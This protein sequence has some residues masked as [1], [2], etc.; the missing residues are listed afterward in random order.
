[1]APE[2]DSLL[3]AE[4]KERCIEE[5]KQQVPI[6]EPR[7]PKSHAAV[8]IPIIELD[9]GAGL[10]YTKRSPRLS[11]HAREVCFPGGKK[12]EKESFIEAALRESN[13]ELGLDPKNIEI[14]TSL[15]PMSSKDVDGT[16]VTP[17]VGVVKDFDLSKLVLN[18]D[19]VCDVFVKGV[20]DLHHPKIA[21]YTQ[22]RPWKKDSKGPGYTLPIY[23]CEPYPIWGMTAIMTFQF[24]NVFLRG[25]T[26]GFKHRLNFQTPLN[27]SKS[28]QKKNPS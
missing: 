19:E 4:N 25:R 24:L 26:K 10:L 27:Y 22:F 28:T 14:W 16:A 2:D 11:S 6:R 13:E 3:S 21:G 20:Y 12:D 23:N 15:P 17:V 7:N 18:P 1:M 9:K 8:L 5:F